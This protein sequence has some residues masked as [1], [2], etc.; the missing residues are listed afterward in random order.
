[1][2]RIRIQNLALEITNKCNL[3]CENC[4][5][6]NTKCV[7]MS[8][9]TI[10]ATFGQIYRINNLHI[11]GGEPTLALDTIENIFKSIIS[12]HV[13]LKQ[14]DVSINGSNYDKDF[15]RLLDYINMYM[16]Y[17]H[18]NSSANF[19]ILRDK[20]HK[21][22]MKKLGIYREALENIKKYVESKHFYKFEKEPSIIT[23]AGIYDSMYV[24]YMNRL[25]FYDRK[26]MCSVGPLITIN[27][28]G[29]IT[30]AVPSI[31]EQEKNYNYGNVFNNSIEEVALK[32]AKLVK[33]AYW[34]YETFRTR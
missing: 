29:V 21:D 27:P 32:K 11:Y 9:D 23:K 22:T 33:P 1:M 18:S 12:N 17:S 20:H 19:N 2:N 3:K 30:E 28:N 8:D 7:F 4:I 34:Y 26:G 15:L 24:T 14:V 6:K 10:N 5:N 13:I 31:K 25:R 16:N